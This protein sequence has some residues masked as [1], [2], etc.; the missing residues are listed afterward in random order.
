VV[1]TRGDGCEV[2]FDSSVDAE[3]TEKLLSELSLEAG[4]E[5]AMDGGD[6]YG[7]T[8]VCLEPFILFTG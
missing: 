8:K 5:E 7:P 3:T 2:K 6:V 1:L 4:D